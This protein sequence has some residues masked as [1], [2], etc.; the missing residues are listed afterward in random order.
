MNVFTKHGAGEHQDKVLY[1]DT[2]T[3]NKPGTQ[4]KTNTCTNTSPLMYG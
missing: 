3:V 1:L 2:G 4:N